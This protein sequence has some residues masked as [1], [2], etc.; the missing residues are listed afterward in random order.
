MNR[1]KNGDRYKN[2]DRYKNLSIKGY[3]DEIKPYLKYL[4]N[5]LQNLHT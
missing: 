1:Y 4:I 2:D 3:L 5:D